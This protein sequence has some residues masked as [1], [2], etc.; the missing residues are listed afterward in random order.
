MINPAI[1]P[2]PAQS[3]GRNSS[4][5]SINKTARKYNPATAKI[6]GKASYI[7]T[8]R[9]ESRASRLYFPSNIH[10]NPSAKTASERD[11]AR[12]MDMRYRKASDIPSRANAH[13]QENGTFWRL[14]KYQMHKKVTAEK[15]TAAH[16]APMRK[17]PKVKGM[18]AT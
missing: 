3:N 1:I 15:K 14:N 10:A 8:Y 2:T 6:N 4:L 18:S 13:N 11:W 7:Q 5:R 12:V 16:L 17:L 9:N